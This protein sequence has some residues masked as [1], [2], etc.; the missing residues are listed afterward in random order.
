[1]SGMIHVEAGVRYCEDAT[2]NGIDEQEDAPKMPFLERSENPHF[3]WV[4]KLDIDAKTGEVIGWKEKYP[5]VTNA[6]SFYKVCDCCHIKYG[7][8]DYDYYVPSFLCLDDEG[9]GDYMYLTIENGFIKG[10]SESRF[11]DFNDFINANE[12]G[13]RSCV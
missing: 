13:N 4:W 7:S 9:Y 11:N 1:M 5:D 8:L 10:W 6:R 3:G 12:G 2:V